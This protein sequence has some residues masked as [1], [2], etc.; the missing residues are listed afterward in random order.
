VVNRDITRTSNLH[1]EVEAPAGFS[2][3]QAR[4]YT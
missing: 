3:L 1:N 2:Q 4:L